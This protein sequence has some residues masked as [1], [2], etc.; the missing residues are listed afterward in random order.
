M[1]IKYVLHKGFVKVVTK[2]RFGL[3]VEAREEDI[4]QLVISSI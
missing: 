2:K 3:K 4:L 1:F